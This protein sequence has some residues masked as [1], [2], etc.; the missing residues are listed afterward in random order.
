[1]A[2]RKFLRSG[3]GALLLATAPAGRSD[4]AAGTPA[5][6]RLSQDAA[7]AEAL[8]AVKAG[9]PHGLIEIRN[10]RI[11]DPVTATVTPGQA[12]IVVEDR[13]AWIGAVATA[14]Q[15]KDMI[16]VDG[17]DRYL[18]PGLTDMHIH[19]SAAGGWL[20]NLAAGVTSVRDMDGFPWILTA[21][22]HINSGAMLGPVTYVAGTIIASRPLD[23]YAVV[24]ANP[25]DARRLVRQEAACGY[26]FIKIHNAL[27][28][29]IFDAVAGQAAQL[30][31]DLVGHVP[32]DI[33]LE[34]AL[35]VGHMRTTEHLKGFLLDATLLP[36][37]EDYAPALAGTE[38][39]I[40]PTLYT[41]YGY[42]RS[43]WAR[44]VLNGPLAQ[45]ASPERRLQWAALLAQ[46]DSSD[47][48]L[49][50][51][52]KTTQGIV[53]KRLL[54]LHPHWLAG[55]D[56]AGYPFNLMGFALL[57]E[58]Q[59]LQDEG[60]SPVEAIRAATVEPAAAMRQPD[61]FGRLAKGMRADLILLDRNPLEGVSA[62]RSN[63]GVMAHGYWLDRRTLDQ[64]LARLAQAYAADQSDP[65]VTQASADA[66]YRRL[67]AARD[68]GFVFDAERLVE[69]AGAL[70]SAHLN[71]LADRIE[72]LAEVSRTGPCA[73]LLPHS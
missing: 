52:L 14:P 8:G 68:A 16:V 20:L 65:P 21:R 51:R 40:T 50:Q 64:A 11:V 39:W 57:E 44:A 54:P 53:M 45:Y 13:I 28:Q 46:P 2:S 10:V 73:E 6:T 3:L 7:I 34:H 18:A 70:R 60:L 17:A 9:A 56:A 72:G 61:E 69:L 43:E 4:R 36:S 67:A 30:G 29:P 26:D 1:M 33:S 25:Q 58:L 19:S 47:V 27:P 24:A 35:H 48:K 42:N 15:V 5:F 41:R 23:G 31:M 63:Q 62:Y 22:D 71:D 12:V 66:L 55:T 37:E 49:G 59:L 32:H 38:T